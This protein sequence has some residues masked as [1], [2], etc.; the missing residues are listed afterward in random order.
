MN[1]QK[2]THVDPRRGIPPFVDLRT[3][4]VPYIGGPGGI[5]PINDCLLGA[6]AGIAGQVYFKNSVGSR[7][8]LDELLDRFGRGFKIVR[9]IRIPIY[10]LLLVRLVVTHFIASSAGLEMAC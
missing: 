8:V 2:L 4:N 7:K 1:A 10:G 9:R 5:V 6:E 3:Q